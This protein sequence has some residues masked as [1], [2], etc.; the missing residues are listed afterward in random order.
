MRI[1]NGNNA[2]TAV[3]RIDQ[4]ATW[5]ANIHAEGCSLGLANGVFD[6]LHVGHLRYLSE[7]KQHC[8]VLV[9]AVNSDESTRRNKGSDRPLVPLDERIEMLAGLRPVDALVAFDSD[10]VEPIIRLI[11]PKF[12]FKGTDYTER[13]VPERK[14]VESC[15][16]K[17]MIVGDPKDH[18]ST[19][20][21][22][23]LSA[24]QKDQR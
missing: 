3:L 1:N 14:V 23:R 4:L 2:T 20:L 6:L 12:H 9:V 8:D 24:L 5:A 19:D 18:A 16:G 11:Q 10:T 17:V 7:A 13:S 15:G 21:I 22:Q